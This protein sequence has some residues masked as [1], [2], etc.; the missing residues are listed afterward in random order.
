MIRNKMVMFNFEPGYQRAPGLRSTNVGLVG[1]YAGLPDNY[2]LSHAKLADL[3]NQFK[4][5]HELQRSTGS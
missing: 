1:Y 3:M 2:G 5:A 4:A